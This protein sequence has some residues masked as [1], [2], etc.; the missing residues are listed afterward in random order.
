[1]KD[2]VTII[3]SLSD[4]LPLK[5]A[6]STDITDAEIRLR[7]SFAEEYKEYL[8]AFGAIMADGVELTGIAKSE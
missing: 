8:A 6:T 3:K 1:M 5:P 4:L 7:V 2:I